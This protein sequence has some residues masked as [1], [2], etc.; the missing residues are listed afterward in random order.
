MVYQST[1]GGEEN[2][3]PSLA[4]VQGLAK[5]GG[6]FVPQEM[7][8]LEKSL[9]D[10]AELS[11]QDL[12]YEIMKLYLTDFTEEELRYCIN[13]AYDDKFSTKE[14]APVVKK[15]DSYYLELFHGRTLAF[16]DMALSILPYLMKVSCKKNQIQEKIVILTATSGDTGK[17]AM[18]GFCDVDGCEIIVF[19]PKDGVSPFQERQMRAQK[20]Q[21][22]HVA[23]ILGNFDDAQSGVKKIFSDKAYQE[24]LL[25]KGYRLSSA[26]SINIGRLVPQ[27]VYY[28]YAYC[29]LLKSGELKAGESLNVS[30]PT[31]NFGN[32]LAAY[33]AKRMGLPLGKLLCASNDNKVLTDFFRTGIYDKNRPFHVTT[34][35]SMDILISSNLERLLYFAGEN[36]E[37]CKKLMEELKEKGKYRISEAMEKELKDFYSGYGKEAEGSQSIFQTYKETGYVLDPHTAVAKVV[38]DHYAYE[39]GRRDKCLVVSTASPYKFSQTVLKALKEPVPK[40]VFEGI[41]ALEKL[42]KEPIPAPVKEVEEGEIRHSTVCSVEDMEATVSHFLLF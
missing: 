2:V 34:S 40:D 12:A 20:G 30:V 25:D 4:I 11:Y 15:G 31:G 1:R 3:S 8:K 6:L 17:A 42:W 28:V 18:E 21:N 35:P 37:E 5:D 22:T 26:N 41:E 23:A 32:I 9:E 39:Q 19:Y 29:R 13:S 14:I 27:I 33:C 24:K 38:A 10:Y 36:A 7:P 16:K